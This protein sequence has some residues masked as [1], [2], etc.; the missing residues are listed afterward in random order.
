MRVATL[1][2][3]AAETDS[4]NELVFLLAFAQIRRSL[5]NSKNRSTP[6]L[7]R[8]AL[9]HVSAVMSLPLFP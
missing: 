7:R 3:V 9:R 1:A 2:C 5:D 6:K 4:M 8:N